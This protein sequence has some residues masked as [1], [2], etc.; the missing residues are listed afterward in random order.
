MGLL[1]FPSLILFLSASLRVLCMSECMMEKLRILLLSL[2]FQGSGI[3]HLLILFKDF[4]FLSL[5]LLPY[6]R[7]A[8]AKTHLSTWSTNMFTCH[9]CTE[10]LLRLLSQKKKSTL[11]TLFFSGFMWLPTQS[12]KEFSCQSCCFTTLLCFERSKV[13][14]RMHTRK[15]FI[16]PLQRVVFQCSQ[17]S[18]R[19]E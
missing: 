19:I 6:P 16:D 13:N 10:Q 17:S 8:V 3:E 2:Y 7:R 5:I 15:C 18:V 11:H 9:S 14:R 4:S 1:F 12:Q